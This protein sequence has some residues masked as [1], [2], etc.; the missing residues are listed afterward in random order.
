MPACNLADHAACFGHWSSAR[1]GQPGEIKTMSKIR[2]ILL[3]SL[4][5]I[6]VASIVTAQKMKAPSGD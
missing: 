3:S 2:N 5:A 4:A 1:F 6:A